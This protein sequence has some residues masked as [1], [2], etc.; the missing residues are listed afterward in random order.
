MVSI[1]K[2]IKEDTTSEVDQ[3]LYSYMIGKLQ[4]VFHTGLD[5]FLAVGIVAGF[6]SNL[7]ETHM[8]VVKRIFIY[9]KIIEDYGVWYK[10]GDDYNLKV[11]IDVD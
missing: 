1:V 6:S 11:Y 9:L 7:K 10:K 8:T 4:Y 5:I 2:L 3:T